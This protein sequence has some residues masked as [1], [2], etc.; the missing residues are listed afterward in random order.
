MFFS[1]LNYNTFLLTRK[2]R[3]KF[4]IKTFNRNE[5]KNVTLFLRLNF[6]RALI[7]VAVK[8]CWKIFVGNVTRVQIVG[9]I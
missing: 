9:T 2:L 8:P 3:I 1:I 7:S 6:E 5:T 4:S